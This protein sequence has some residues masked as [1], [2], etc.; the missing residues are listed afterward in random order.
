M[1]FLN[2]FPAVRRALP[3]LLSLAVIAGGSLLI[4]ACG[5]SSSGSSGNSPSTSSS[6]TSSQSTSQSPSGDAAAS[7]STIKVPGYGTVL[8]TAKGAALYL[9][10]ADPTGSSSCSGS[11][12]TA[13]PPL[14]VTG[15]PVAG[16]GVSASL[17][18]S[19]KRSDGSEQVLY[20][21][22][23]LY[24]HPGLSATASAGTAGD[25]GIWYLV[26]PSG[27][28]VKTTNGSGY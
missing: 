26:S 4:A 28:P 23:A 6:A 19:F 17:L 10:T 13:W 25:G 27:S 1:H 2:Q 14:T 18:S 11:C 7:V 20:D 16:A 5:S 12:A 8:A 24:T 3:L 15:K 22:H 9:L 21:G